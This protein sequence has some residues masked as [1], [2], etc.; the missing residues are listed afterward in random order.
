[1]RIVQL[2]LIEKAKLYMAVGRWQPRIIKPNN[3]FLKLERSS[4]Y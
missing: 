2:E 4:K 1:M 3:I